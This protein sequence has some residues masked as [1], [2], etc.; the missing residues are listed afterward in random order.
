MACCPCLSYN[1]TGGVGGGVNV[2]GGDSGDGWVLGV[3]VVT[4]ALMVALEIV[5]E[6]LYLVYTWWLWRHLWWCGAHGCSG[7]S[8]GD[9]GSVGN[10]CG[11]GDSGVD[12]GVGFCKGVIAIVVVVLVHTSRG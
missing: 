6:K 9:G 8:G 5:V 2:I 10:G 3:V 4:A 7:I 12:G 1:L 11:S